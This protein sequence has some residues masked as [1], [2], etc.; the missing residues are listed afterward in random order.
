MHE[1]RGEERDFRKI[2]FFRKELPQY[3]KSLEKIWLYYNFVWRLMVCKHE[4]YLGEDKVKCSTVSF[5]SL[6]FANSVRS[7]L[8]IWM[9]HLAHRRHEVFFIFSR[10]VHYDFF[11]N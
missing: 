5:G 6:N 7:M 11:K 9:I 1:N 10:E 2:F 4:K 8:H 3:E